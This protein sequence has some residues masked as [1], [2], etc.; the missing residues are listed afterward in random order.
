MSIEHLST[1]FFSK[2]EN[3]V[4][5]FRKVLS[6][7]G[8]GFKSVKT[9]KAFTTALFTRVWGLILLDDLLPPAAFKNALAQL[10]TKVTDTPIIVLSGDDLTH[11]DAYL[12]AGADDVIIKGA[13]D[14]LGPAVIRARNNIAR[15]KEI[16]RGGKIQAAFEKYIQNAFVEQSLD[17][18]YKSIH[19][20]VGELMP[21]EN[22]YISFYD[23]ELDQV[24][25]PYYLDQYDT[26]PDPERPGRSLTAYVLRTGEPL[27]ASPEVFNQLVDIGE[28]ELLGAPSIDW[29]GVPLKVA[30]QTVGAMVVQSY[31]EGLRYS[32]E[33]AQLLAFFASQIALSLERKRAEDSLQ[34]E[35]TFR[36]AIETSITS[37]IVFFD[38]ELRLTYV[39]PAFCRLVGWTQEELLNATPPFIYWPEEDIETIQEVLSITT[40]VD[41]LVGDFELRFKRKNGEYFDALIMSSPVLGGEQTPTGW[42]WSVYDNTAR[43][44]VDTALRK[45]EERYRQAVENSPNPIF[46]VSKSNTVQLWNQ[47]CESVFEYGQEIIGRDY[48][49][50]I[51]KPETALLISQLVEK[52]FQKE[53]S[54]DLDIEF[55]T[56]SGRRVFMITRLYPLQ[57]ADGNI[58]GCVFAGTDITSRRIAELGLKRRDEILQVVSYG[59]VEFLRTMRWEENLSSFLQQLGIV[60]DASRVIIFENISGMDAAIYQHVLQLWNSSPELSAT[61]EIEDVSLV[62]PGYENIFARLNRGEIYFGRVDEMSLGEQEIFSKQRVRSLIA[63]PIYIGY[64]WWGSIRLDDCLTDRDWS[65]AEKDALR[66]AAGIIG[67]AIQD[68]RARELSRRQTGRAEALARTASRLNAQLDLDSVLNTIC[69]ET[70]RA[71]NYPAVSV[72]LFNAETKCFNMA[73]SSGLPLEIAS[74]GKPMPASMIERF[75]DSS[76]PVFVITDLLEFPDFPNYTL[77]E[78]F[79]IRSLASTRMIRDGEMVGGL[80]VYS[81]NE[82]KIAS[83]DELELLASMAAQAAQ[84]ILNAR[85]FAETERRLRQ[86][87]ALRS[88]DLA[89]SASLDLRVILNILL[90]QVMSQL[91]VDAVDVLL[92]SPNAYELEVAVSRGFRMS[93]ITHQRVLLSEAPTSQVIGE[94]K[95]ILFDDLNLSGGSYSRAPLWSM[96]GFIAYAGYPLLAKGQVKGVLELYHRHP[97]TPDAEWREFLE[98][99]AGQAAI[100]IENTSL[101]E[102]LQNSNDELVL[103]YDTTLEGWTR[104]LDMRESTAAGHSTRVTELTLRIAR[105][106]GVREDDFIHLRR[107]ALLHDIGTMAISDRILDKPNP[108]T[109][110]EWET[111]RK[112]PIYAYQL[113]SPINY[114]HPALDI[115]CYHH[116]RWNGSG[117]PEG[118]VGEQIPLAARIFAVVDVWDALLTERPFR[119]AWS[120]EQA[121]EYILEQ[122]GKLFDPIIVQA[123]IKVVRGEESDLDRV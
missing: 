93:R 36:K 67:A 81:Y 5:T 109:L 112:H 101:F 39:N 6:E 11:L 33:D 116:E 73:A 72:T 95:L 66:T 111:I 89:I 77:Y 85:L 98:A 91:K 27:L 49:M 68:R 50:L 52:I 23:P 13:P 35:Y 41:A 2:D 90:D 110:D 32:Q 92:F 12:Q 16:R 17:E 107:G 1:L 48:R 123:F 106:V 97:F 14:R 64:E 100:A 20:A 59:A 30:E 55:Q 4:T 9:P 103:A 119:S 25:Y 117:Y 43:K 83:P 46:V 94:R 120:E 61:G 99:L 76:N 69:E 113:L 29:L 84:A 115:P 44:R 42:L 114:L 7:S 38:T 121:I 21:A 3:L 87:H 8:S 24:S 105:A 60:T 15:R 62:S 65:P 88:V 102:Q 57:D 96:E 26:R 58:Q 80:N 40:Q 28:V 37:G 51:T 79:H 78:K 71:L 70:I 45:S 75:Y 108:L 118:L 47:A 104:A 18:L 56:N 10:Q 31:T 34:Q 53:R 22:F 122:A 19:T 54:G 86:V 82:V 63:V 74:E